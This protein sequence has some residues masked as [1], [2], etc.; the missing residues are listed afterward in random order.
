LRRPLLI[1]GRNLYEPAAV[2]GLGFEYI[3]VARAPVSMAE[4]AVEMMLRD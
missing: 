4:S 3:G 2:I 1:D